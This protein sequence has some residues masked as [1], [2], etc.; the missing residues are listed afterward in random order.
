MYV[1]CNFVN[2]N[3]KLLSVGQF[4]HFNETE[5]MRKDFRLSKQ[6][7]DFS[8]RDVNER[9]CIISQTLMVYTFSSI[10]QFLFWLRYK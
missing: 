4:F 10:V 9:F 8:I 6:E 2:L 1:L 5:P 7:A 3:T